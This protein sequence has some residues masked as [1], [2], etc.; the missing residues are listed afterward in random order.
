MISILFLNIKYLSL[1][2]LALLS[3]SWGRFEL[4]V[5]GFGIGGYCDARY[6]EFVSVQ[7]LADKNPRVA[8]SLCS[9]FIIN[10]AIYLYIYARSY[11]VSEV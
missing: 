8:Y 3:I 5:V 6:S 10:S 4:A 1:V 7:A 2:A 11:K 9:F